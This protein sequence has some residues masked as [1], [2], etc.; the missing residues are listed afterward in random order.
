M[1]DSNRQYGDYSS[2]VTYERGP[3]S[4]PR[5]YGR[6][7][8][9]DHPSE[10]LTPGFYFGQLVLLWL[11]YIPILGIILSIR[12]TKHSKK[13]EYTVSHRSFYKLMSILGWIYTVLATIGI[14]VTIIL[15]VYVGS[16]IAQVIELDSLYALANQQNQ[17]NQQ[18]E[19]NND[20]EDTGDV[21]NW[22]LD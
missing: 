14:I 21:F 17:Q 13:L 9:M 15:T 19:Y 22:S 10:N 2:Y 3:D 18:I 16:V 6:G 5:Q 4:D 1:D 7:Y 12:F 20:I 11:C 8:G